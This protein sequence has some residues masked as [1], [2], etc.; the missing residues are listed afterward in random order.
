MSCI[1]HHLMNGRVLF[2][3][4]FFLQNPCGMRLA[5]GLCLCVRDV[6][7]CLPHGFCKGRAAAAWSSANAKALH[8]AALCLQC[9]EGGSAKVMERDPDLDFNSDP[10]PDPDPD[11]KHNPK[12]KS[13]GN[14]AVAAQSGK[15]GITAL[16][17]I[18]CLV[19]KWGQSRLAA[20]PECRNQSI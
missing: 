2:V 3:H 6:R 9:R 17:C 13:G 20:K 5:A 12:S 1:V 4:S 11:L 8:G 10:D 16:R 7:S 18:R 14:A 19:K 15:W